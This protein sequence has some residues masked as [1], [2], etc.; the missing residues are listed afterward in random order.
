MDRAALV[1]LV[2]E[3]GLCP[4]L[5]EARAVRIFVAHADGHKGESMS[6][7]AFVRCLSAL[8]VEVFGGSACEGRQR[9]LEHMAGSEVTTELHRALSGMPEGKALRTLRSS[10]APPPASAT[11]LSNASSLLSV[12]ELTAVNSTLKQSCD[13]QGRLTFAALSQLAHQCKLTRAPGE[14]LTAVHL[15][16][17][18]SIEALRR[19]EEE[20]GAYHSDQF[21]VIKSASTAQKCGVRSTEQFVRLLMHLGC[22]KYPD[23]A[24]EEAALQL[25]VRL[26]LIPY[27]SA[28][29]TEQPLQNFFSPEL[30]ALLDSAEEELGAVFLQYGEASTSVHPGMSKEQWLLFNREYNLLRLSSQRQLR[31][32]F[33]QESEHNGKLSLEGFVN[34]LCC[35]AEADAKARGLQSSPE[36]QM[37]AL[38]V[39][40]E[41]SASFECLD[42]SNKHV[43]TKANMS[44]A[45]VEQPKPRQGL[46]P[47]W[48]NVF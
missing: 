13:Q 19:T 23:A 35:V 46:H 36:E 33:Q 12:D 31:A 15:D 30:V 1:C 22:L 20:R 40:I 29:P 8:G 7:C 17:A 24:D 48:A 11:S 2:Q 47:K 38:L 37:H 25:I 45:P 9:L 26:H 4:M 21:A 28:P 42:V 5:S 16:S 6:F 39:L 44:P 27:L 34:A 41:S 43:A 10:Q 14:A 3:Y 18:Y 32:V